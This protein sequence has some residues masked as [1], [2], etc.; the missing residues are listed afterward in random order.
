MKWGFRIR[1]IVTIALKHTNNLI[2]VDDKVIDDNVCRSLLLHVLWS[3]AVSYIL[4]LWVLLFWPIIC[5]WPVVR[6]WWA[7][8]WR[9]LIS[10]K[11]WV[12][13]VFVNPFDYEVVN[14]SVI[15]AVITRNVVN[16]IWVRWGGWVVL[17]LVKTSRSIVP[18]KLV[19]L[20]SLDARVFMNFLVMVPAGIG[21]LRSRRKLWT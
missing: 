1:T 4:L 8:A 7:E 18:E 19:T 13:F 9:V 6:E 12:G 3:P 11:S 5:L 16:D 2:F 14:L 17:V 20:M 10:I 15:G 21:R